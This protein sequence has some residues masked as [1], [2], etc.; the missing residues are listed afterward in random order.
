MTYEK[1]TGAINL[2][3][4]EIKA[5]EIKEVSAASLLSDHIWDLDIVLAVWLN[6]Y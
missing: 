5:E 1:M 6:C 3:E 4:L 2:E